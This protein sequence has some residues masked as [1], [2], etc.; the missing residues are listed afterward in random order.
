M[1]YVD[2]HACFALGCGPICATKPEEIALLPSQEV[3]HSTVSSAQ[4]RRPVCNCG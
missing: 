1:A 4:Q 3:S 2:L